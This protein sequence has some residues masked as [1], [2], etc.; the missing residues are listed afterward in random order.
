[1]AAFAAVHGLNPLQ[2]L[3]CA[4]LFIY[5]SQASRWASSELKATRGSCRL[6]VPVKTRNNTTSKGKLKTDP[7]NLY[8]R[9]GHHD[10]ATKIAALPEQKFFG[11]VTV[12]AKAKTF[13]A[14]MG[15]VAKLLCTNRRGVSAIGCPRMLSVA[16]L[17]P[18]QATDSRYSL[19]PHRHNTWIDRRH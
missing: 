17:A 5:A 11:S 13:S 16:R 8:T 3:L 10:A 9:P 15:D 4:W 6:L 14:Y 19:W 1:V 12:D 18:A 2:D 7:Y